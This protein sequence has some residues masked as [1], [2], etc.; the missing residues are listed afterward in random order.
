MGLPGGARLGAWIGRQAVRRGLLGSSRIWL[1]V[2][3]AGRL[4][5]VARRA[6]G[7]KR[8]PVALS[9]KLAPG[10]ALEIRHLRRGRR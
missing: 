8:A 3:V 5:R 10:S 4:G 6:L 1:A 7:P 9:E 2:F